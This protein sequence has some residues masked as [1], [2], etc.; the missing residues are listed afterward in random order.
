MQQ[1][2]TS[3]HVYRQAQGSQSLYLLLRPRD[4]YKGVP[5]SASSHSGGVS[6][7]CHPQN[8]DCHVRMLCPVSHD[9]SSRVLVSCPVPCFLVQLC[10]CRASL[11]VMYCTVLCIGAVYCIPR[12]PTFHVLVCLGLVS[13]CSCC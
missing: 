10:L 12:K 1:I 5:R 7:G 11:H 8:C 3:L 4:L 6:R 13:A 9:M 2:S